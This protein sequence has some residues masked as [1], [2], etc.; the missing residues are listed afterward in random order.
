MTSDNESTA[1]S[2]DEWIVVARLVR[3]QGCHGEVLA[4]IHTDFPEK[5]AER[6]R[7]F[8]LHPGARAKAAAPPREIQVEDHWLHKDRVVFK[9][10]GID[11]I[12]QAETLRGLDAA[13]PLSERAPLEDDA[14]YVADLIG[15]TLVQSGSGAEI[16]VVLAVNKEVTSAPLLEVRS[17]QWGEV[18]VPFVKAYL[19]RV[20]IA[21]KRIE[22]DLPEGLLEVNMPSTGAERREPDAGSET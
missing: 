4:E 13:I 11:S 15:C 8:L 19:K 14:V 17:N 2:A 1:A 18:L 16:G 10:A 5:F 21:A 20:D 9:F 22:M 6:K 12:E 3:P 7:L